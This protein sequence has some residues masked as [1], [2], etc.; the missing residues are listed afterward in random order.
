MFKNASECCCFSF[1]RP[2][3][4][5]DEEENAEEE[6]DREEE[7]AYKQK[8]EYPEV[9]GEESG[10]T[11]TKSNREGENKNKLNGNYEHETENV[12]QAEEEDLI[13]LNGKINEENGEGMEQMNSQEDLQHEE[14]VKEDYSGSQNQ[15]SIYSFSL[16]FLS[17]RS[18][19]LS[20]SGFFSASL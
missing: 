2:A 16:F 14:D 10:E 13:H 20:A 8:E 17:Y 9:N 3:E 15:V 4:T 5:V 18:S 6:N 12:D 11:V 19:Y 7:E 1:Q